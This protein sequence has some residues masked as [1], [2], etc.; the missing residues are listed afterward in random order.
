MK[1]SLGPVGSLVVLVCA[2]S[3]GCEKPVPVAPPDPVRP[4]KLIEVKATSDIRQVKLPAVIEASNSTVLAFQ[5]GG[6]LEQLEVTEG[7]D[8]STGTVIGRLNPRDFQNSVKQAQA[9]YTSANT[10]YQRARRLLEQNAIARSVVDQ[11]RAARDIAR[12]SLDSAQK[13][14]EDSVLKTPFEGR[15]ATV[16]VEQFESVGPQQP[17]VTLQ[18]VGAAEAVVEIPSTLVANRERL[19]PIE[20]Y[21]TLD[22]VGDIRIPAEFLSL[23]PLA[24]AATQTF[25]AKFKFLPPEGVNILPGM[26]G[27]LNGTLRI[28]A[29]DGTSTTQL[30]IP[31]SS[32]LS[33][34]ADTF[35]WVVDTEAM[36]VSKRAVT[37][38]E[39]VG[40]SL[41][42]ESGLKAGETIAGA[43]ASYLVEGKQVRAYGN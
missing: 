39:G 23:S 20:S 15:I 10:E 27:S 13:A 21:V 9:Q 16:A 6:K 32:I 14:L 1:G 28:A 7:Q 3:S 37:L 41:F 8:V 17:I 31:L 42:V 35:V 36:T 43:G 25:A 22:A 38:T 26:T 5:V 24:N 4:V 12:A 34:G 30:A 40:E 18:T 29:E 2:L 33:E 11:R 19:T